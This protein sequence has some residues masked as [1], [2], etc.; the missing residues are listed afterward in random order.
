MLEPMTPGQIVAIILGLPL[1]ASGAVHPLGSAAEKLFKFW[2]AAK[3][4]ND[5]QNDR[6]DA[7]EKWKQEVDR[8]LNSD[9]GQLKELNRGLHALYRS[10]LALLDHGLDGNN[11]EQMK[12]AK[13]ELL[14]QL[15]D[16]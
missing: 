3:A 2:K 1:V 16:K 15:I 5:D 11:I 13:A 4:P 8:K 12:S 7:L 14:D 6:L 9:N 10:N